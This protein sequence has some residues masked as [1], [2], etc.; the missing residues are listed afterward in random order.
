[1]ASRPVTMRL[2]S[3]IRSDLVR[4]HE[5]CESY[6][7]R[8]EFRGRR[9]RC[10]RNLRNLVSSRRS[11]VEPA[12][13]IWIFHDLSVGRI[14]C[15]VLVFGRWRRH[16]R[17]GSSVSWCRS[18]SLRCPIGKPI[19]KVATSSD[20]RR[21]ARCV[22]RCIG[23]RIASLVL[24]RTL[25][26]DPWSRRNDVPLGSR[27]GISRASGGCQLGT[28]ERASCLNLV[29][30][31]WREGSHRCLMFPQLRRADVHHPTADGRVALSITGVR[32]GRI[33]GRR[34]TS[35]STLLGL[36]PH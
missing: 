32:L 7:W 17:R 9:H 24:A 18:G 5:S 21:H 20:G 1:M 25:E 35:P 6:C 34:A 30:R 26:V 23:H 36:T 28:P 14:Q 31:D 33:C 27:G 22:G 15:G 13:L 10:G 4:S 19:E 29:S 16:P 8:A 11:N 2:K 12:F 3:E